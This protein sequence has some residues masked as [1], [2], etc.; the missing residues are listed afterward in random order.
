M[1][2]RMTTD[3]RSV[4]LRGIM[5]EIFSDVTRQEEF[6]AK[7]IAERAGISVVWFYHICGEEFRELRSK[8]EGNRKPNETVIH[9]LKVQ[10]KA[11][12][13]EVRELRVKLK[14]AAIEEISEA[15]RIIESL[16]AENRMLRAEVKMLRQRIAESE[17]ISISTFR[18]GA[19]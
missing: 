8:L 16:D 12:R 15:I 10:I 14:A 1:G 17:V 11:L 6:T 3:K 2:Q 19:K 13:K 4:I 5:H 7:K 9:K 18:S